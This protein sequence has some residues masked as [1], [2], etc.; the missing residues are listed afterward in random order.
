[1][2][3]TNIVDSGLG[4]AVIQISRRMKRRVTAA[5]VA[6][7]CNIVDEFPPLRPIYLDL[8]LMPRLEL[9]SGEDPSLRHISLKNLLGTTS[10]KTKRDG[11]RCLG[12]CLRTPTEQYK[13]RPSRAWHARAPSGTSQATEEDD[14]VLQATYVLVNLS[15]GAATYQTHSTS[16]VLLAERGPHV[17][18]PVMSAMLELARALIEAGVGA[19]LR[20]MCS[21]GAGARYP[22]SVAM[23]YLL[24]MTFNYIGNA[25]MAKPFVELEVALETPVQSVLFSPLGNKGTIKV[26]GTFV[27]WDS[28]MPTECIGSTRSPSASSFAPGVRVLKT[29]QVISA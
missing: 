17:R 26:I 16:G 3:R 18:R 1:M 27:P 15:N 2:L 7:V 21:I 10:G 22:S 25:N 4:M 20:Q 9:L 11:M 8:A 6:A 19:T 28:S 13:S 5:A 14:I 23:L 29:E 12:C 24:C